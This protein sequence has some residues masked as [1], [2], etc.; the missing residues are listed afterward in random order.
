VEVSVRTVHD[1]ED[2]D[3]VRALCD[4]VWP[5]PTESTQVTLNLLRAIEHAGGHVGAA[6][7]EHGSLVG[8]TV[9]LLGRHRDLGSA[10]WAVHLHS[11][12]AAVA[13][14]ARDRHV[15]SSLKQHQRAWSLA[16]DVAE[17]WWTFDPLVRRNLRFN[18]LRLG[19]DITDYLP[20]FY[21]SMDD[22]VN[23]G[24]RSDRLLVRWRLESPRAQEAAAGLL[25]PDSTEALRAMGAEDALYI[26]RGLPEVVDPAPPRDAVLLVP[27]PPDITVLRALDAELG[28]RW[29]LTVRTVLQPALAAGRPVQGITQDGHYVLGPWP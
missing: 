5:S 26:R 12:M 20:D 28:L 18:L 25:T 24:D 15:G 16:N 2:L 22:T 19:A 8:A 17:I 9:A 29:R 7:D 4:A 21:G 13:P 14:Q 27:L 10:G 3:A 1:L 23:A 6:Y 11:H